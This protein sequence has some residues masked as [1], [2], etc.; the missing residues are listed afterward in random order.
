MGMPGGRHADGLYRYF[1]YGNRAPDIDRHYRAAATGKIHHRERRE[2]Q[3]V[4]DE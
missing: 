1:T 2:K 4:I 3:C